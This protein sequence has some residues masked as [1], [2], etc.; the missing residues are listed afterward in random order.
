LLNHLDMVTTQGYA[1]LPGDN[2][3]EAPL[4]MSAVIS[5]ALKANRQEA[6]EA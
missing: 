3:R 6:A 1:H 4:Q 2:L 5:D